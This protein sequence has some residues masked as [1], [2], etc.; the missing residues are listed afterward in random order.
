MF[1]ARRAH[2]CLSIARARL[3]HGIDKPPYQFLEYIKPWIDTVSFAV[4]SGTSLQIHDAHAYYMRK[5]K[6]SY[7]GMPNSTKQCF[8]LLYLAVRGDGGYIDWKINNDTSI[9]NDSVQRAMFGHAPLISHNWEMFFRYSILTR[10]NTIPLHPIRSEGFT[11]IGWAPDNGW[12]LRMWQFFLIKLIVDR[13]SSPKGP[14]NIIS[15]F[16]REGAGPYCRIVITRRDQKRNVT[17]CFRQAQS[18]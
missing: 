5:V 17:F 4:D 12:S 10:D 6:N 13:F 18:Y 11:T 16:I 14:V 1:K 9:L 7:T 8:N 3:G 15:R 2:I